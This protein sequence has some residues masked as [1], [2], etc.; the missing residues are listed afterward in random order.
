MLFSGKITMGTKD[1]V[2]YKLIFNINDLITNC[3]T[4]QIEIVRG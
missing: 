2:I 1:E 3:T 4:T